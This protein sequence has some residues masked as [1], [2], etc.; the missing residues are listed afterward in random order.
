MSAGAVNI[1]VTQEADFEAG[2]HR[3]ADY[4]NVE[5]VPDSEMQARGGAYRDCHLA[6]TQIQSFYLQSEQR[7]P[8]LSEDRCS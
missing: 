6:R 4:A 8:G 5:A 2:A 7:F 3:S 1:P